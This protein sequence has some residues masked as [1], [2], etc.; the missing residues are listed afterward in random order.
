MNVLLWLENEAN[1]LR[2]NVMERVGLGSGGR[3]G[4]NGRPAAP[5]AQANT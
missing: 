3:Y 5:V 1:T 4:A 2:S